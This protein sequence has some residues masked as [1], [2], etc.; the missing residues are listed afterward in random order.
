MELDDVDAI[1]VGKYVYWMGQ[2]DDIPRGHLGE[3]TKA[4]GF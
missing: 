2:D 1:T 3:V 4:G